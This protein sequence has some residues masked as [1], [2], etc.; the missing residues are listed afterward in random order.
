MTEAQKD[1]DYLF[2]SAISLLDELL[3]LSEPKE[4]DR[5]NALKVWERASMARTIIVELRRF[6]L[7][8][9]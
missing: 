8:K 3:L 1:I 9:E 2:G 6:C 4:V 5:A 7:K